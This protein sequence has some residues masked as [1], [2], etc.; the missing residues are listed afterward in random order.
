MAS[1]CWLGKGLQM[2][3]VP[4]SAPIGTEEVVREHPTALDESESLGPKRVISQSLAVSQQHYYKIGARNMW[5]IRDQ[6]KS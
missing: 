3:T 6:V 2:R 4:V 1:L 5:E